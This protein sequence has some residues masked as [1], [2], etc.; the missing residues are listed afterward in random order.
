MLHGEAVFSDCV[1]ELDEAGGGG[2]ER[3]LIFPLSGESA[4]LNWLSDTDGS[5]L[6]LILVICLVGGDD[7]GDGGGDFTALPYSITMEI[8]LCWL[9]SV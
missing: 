4:A 6:P 1:G 3:F 7:F 5:S 2:G 8:L 9:S